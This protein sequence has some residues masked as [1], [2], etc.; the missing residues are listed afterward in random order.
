M[1]GFTDNI[2]PSAARAAPMRPPLRRFSS[3]SSAAKICIRPFL[4]STIATVSSRD[5]PAAAASAAAIASKPWAIVTLRLS[6]T[7]TSMVLL[8]ASAASWADWYVADKL[9]DNVTHTTPSAPCAAALRNASSNAPGDGAAV[10]GSVLELAVFVQNS[11]GVR[12]RR[13]TYS[14]SPNR[15]VSGTIS[16]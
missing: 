5:F 7:R 12:S 11:L 2:E 13:S 15:I 16:I 1:S 4:S 3:V 14:D 8:T 10:S 9:D 6:T